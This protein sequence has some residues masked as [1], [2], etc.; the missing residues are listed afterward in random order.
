M[1]LDIER[2]LLPEVVVGDDLCTTS[3]FDLIH[4]HRANDAVGKHTYNQTKQHQQH[5]TQTHNNTD[6]QQQ[7]RYTTQT[8]NNNTHTQHRHTTTTQIHNTDTQQHR[9]ITTAQIH[10]NNS[11][12]T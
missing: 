6:T 8:H 3:T 4:H 1:Y 11:T 2:K 9:Y 5:T 12:H 7:H 10:N